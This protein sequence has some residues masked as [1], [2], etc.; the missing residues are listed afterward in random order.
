M[1]QLFV[2]LFFA[3]LCAAPVRPVTAQATPSLSAPAPLLR[4]YVDCPN[5][6]CDRDFFFREIAFVSFTR[7]RNDADVHLLSTG[8]MNGGGGQQVTMQF[9]GLRAFAGRVD[10]LTTSIA[11][12]ATEDNIRREMVRVFKLGLVRFVATT[13]AAKQLRVEFEAPANGAVNSPMRDPWDSWIFDVSGNGSFGG[14]SQS[15]RRSVSYSTSARRVTEALK[16]SFSL[17]GS[18][19]ESHYTYDDGTSSSFILR[20]WGGTSRVAKSLTDHW[21]VGG[22][23]SFGHSE[24]N[25]QD[26]YAKVVG[27]AEY[28]FFPWKQASQHQLVALYAIGGATYRYQEATIF[29]KMKETRPLHQ[30]I[31]ASQVKEPWG[32]FDASLS[33]S[34]YL[35]DLS[36]QNASAFLSTNIRIARGLSLNFFGTASIVHDQLYIAAGGLTPAE[37]LTSQRSLATTFSYGGFVGLSYTFGS[38]LNSIVNPRLDALNGGGQTFFFF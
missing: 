25:N 18:Y 7:D 20:S 14:E 15:T 32:S 3:V 21:S 2:S 16:F 34:Q 33:F 6:M 27:S 36:K 5:V 4:V 29:D 24:F 1:R 28:N 9:I 26:L 8:L 35:H 37:I 12:D 10:T 38:I 30:V 31:L 22:T 17:N 13:A 11:S 23:G 19:R